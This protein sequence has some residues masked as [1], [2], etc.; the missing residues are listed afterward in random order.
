M[1]AITLLLHVDVER[2]DHASR[3]SDSSLCAT[4]IDFLQLLKICAE[5]IIVM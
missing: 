4:C 3:R 2:S 5:L 1:E